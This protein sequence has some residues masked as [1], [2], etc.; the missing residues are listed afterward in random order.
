MKILKTP[1]IVLLALL[2]LSEKISAQ[3]AIDGNINIIKTYRLDRSSSFQSRV[4]STVTSAVEQFN[5][6]HHRLKI[7]LD[8]PSNGIDM[9]LDI[10]KAKQGTKK[11]RLIAYIVNIL[12]PVYIPAHSIKSTLTAPAGVYSM[13]KTQR[14]NSSTHIL[15]GKIRN[16]EDKMLRKYHGKLLAQLK[17]ID[18]QLPLQAMSPGEVKTSNSTK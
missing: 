4:D 10:S 16:R 9:F 5:R 18:A 15:V 8:E 12:V 7:T 6:G 3:S 2:A 11:Q 14:L 1:V 13:P 17:Y